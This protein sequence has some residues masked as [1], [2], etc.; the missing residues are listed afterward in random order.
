MD[1][2]ISR[3]EQDLEIP[4][5]RI[6]PT[7]RIKEVPEMDSMGILSVMTMVDSEYG[8]VLKPDDIARCETVGD[9]WEAVSTRLATV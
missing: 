9:L 5:G 7:S 6:G 3:M 1:E 2:F 4:A 8:I